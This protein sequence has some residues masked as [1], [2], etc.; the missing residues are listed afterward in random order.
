MRLLALVPAVLVLGGAVAGP[1]PPLTNEDL[2][3]MARAGL[4][5]AV[6]IERIKGSTT[7]FRLDA[8]SLGDLVAGGVP[9]PVIRV[10]FARQSAD[11]GASGPAWGEADARRAWADVMRVSGKG[12]ASGDVQLLERG[13]RFVVTGETGCTDAGMA[14]AV[15]WDEVEAV[16]FTYAVTEGRPIGTVVVRTKPGSSYRIRGSRAAVQEIEGEIG[17]GRPRLEVRCD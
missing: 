4:S 8:A 11:S 9:D 13:L 5:S 12:R 3:A 6:I 16:C 14:F 17:S 7:D 2:I 15:A 10:M 1:E